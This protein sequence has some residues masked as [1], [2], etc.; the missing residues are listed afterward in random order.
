VSGSTSHG[1]DAR[2]RL[3]CVYC[4]EE[5]I[6]GREEKGMRRCSGP[7][8]NL[9]GPSRAGIRNMLRFSWKNQGKRWRGVRRA[10][11]VDSETRSQK[12]K[13]LVRGGLSR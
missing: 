9:V 6:R 2:Q 12:G 13:N 7:G 4:S 5:G 3:G 8:K 11:I 1:T 10:R